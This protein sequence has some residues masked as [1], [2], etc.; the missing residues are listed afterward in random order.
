MAAVTAADA[1]RARAAPRS[2][3]RAVT[4]L[5][6]GMLVILA[7]IGFLAYQGLQNALVFYITP[8]ELLA[9]GPADVGVQL[10]LGAE[11]RPGSL[12][13]NRTTHIVRFVLEDSRAK[14]PV[15]S[16]AVPPAMLRGGIGAVVQGE[17]RN[18][19]FWASSIMVKHS[20]DYVAPKNGQAPSDSQYSNK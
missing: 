11:V 4:Q 12:H 13:F 2:S 17:Y 7:A 9:K 14:V 6:I 16:S 15:V 1:L 10:R 19:T 18:R 20:S 5:A 8:S 3:R